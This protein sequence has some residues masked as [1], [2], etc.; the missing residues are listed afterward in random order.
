MEEFLG[1]WTSKRRAWLYGVVTSLVPLL[2]SLGIITG[3]IAGMVLQGAAAI[4]AVGSGTMAIA[5]LTPDDIMV[6]G[7]RVEEEQNDTA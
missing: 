1:F 4:L 7:L 3:D 2:V 6:V 5:N